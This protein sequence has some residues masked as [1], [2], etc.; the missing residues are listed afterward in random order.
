MYAA[1]GIFSAYIGTDNAKNEK[2]GES[3]K[4]DPSQS[5]PVAVSNS[6]VGDFD[7]RRLQDRPRTRSDHNAVP[8]HGNPEPICYDGDKGGQR[9]R[10]DRSYWPRREAEITLLGAG[11]S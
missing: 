3:R 2:R 9:R 6:P 7:A 4:V 11:G 5:F 8:S 10:P 1:T